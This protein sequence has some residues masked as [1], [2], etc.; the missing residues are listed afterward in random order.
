METISTLSVLAFFIVAGTFIVGMAKPNKFGSQKHV[1]TRKG[2]SLVFVPIMVALLILA[3]ATTPDSPKQ[4][5]DTQLKHEMAA[6]PIQA[7]KAKP[8][9]KDVVTTKRLVKTKVIGH[10]TL[11]RPDGLL[12]KG[13]TKV[14]QAGKNG[15]RISVYK[16]TLVNGKEAK[17][18]RV[19]ST[20]TM[21]EQKIVAVGTYV[22]PAPS[23]S[24]YTNVDGY[25]VRSPS[26]DPAGASAQ[27][28][29][30]SYSY[31]MHRQGTCSHHGGVARW[32]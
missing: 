19:S 31:S 32:L 18:M 26:S 2:L 17:R 15:L 28:T 3:G 25:H 6:S 14:V 27:C 13:Q 20:L 10:S 21:P 8:K 23:G 9:P 29:D 1:T 7:P 22:M 16:I 11:E 4:A 30:G 5:A 12:P 24:G